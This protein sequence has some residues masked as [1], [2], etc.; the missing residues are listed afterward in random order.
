MFSSVHQSHF[1][2]P[3]CWNC[4]APLGQSPPKRDELAVNSPNDVRG[5][6]S[7]QIPRET[8]AAGG[9]HSTRRFKS[10]VYVR[11]TQFNATETLRKKIKIK[12]FSK[13]LLTSILQPEKVPFPK[14]WNFSLLDLLL[15]S[16]WKINRTAKQSAMIRQTADGL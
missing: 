9:T 14:P 6:I 16:P 2:C 4:C 13:K 11:F 12:H 15:L 5:Q 8:Q 3:L 10:H 7:F 1:T